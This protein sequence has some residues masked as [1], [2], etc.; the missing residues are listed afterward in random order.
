[1]T[2]IALSEDQAFQLGIEAYIYGYPLILMDITKA[3]STTVSAPQGFKAPINQ[4]AHL[5]AFPDASFTAVVSPNAD[6]LYSAAWLD[7]SSEPMVLSVPDTKGRYYLMPMLDAWTNVFASPGKRTT[8]TG[9]GDF[10]I[11]APDWTGKLPDGVQKIQSPTA[12]VW[13][14]GRTQ[15]NGKA[16]YEAV[17]AIQDQYQLTPLSQ[18]GK[19]YQP[20]TNVPIAE[21]IDPQ[22]APVE[23]VKN[24]DAATFFSRMS[25]L[26]KDNPPAPE[27]KEMVQK[28]AEI[29]I[30]QGEDFNFQS[31]DPAVVKGLERSVKAGQEKVVADGKSPKAEVKNHWLMTYDLGN[32]G[33]NY[34]HRAGVAWVGLG[35]N[36]PEDAIY[37]M[38]RVDEEGNLLT[39]E[40]RYVIHF[41][42][43][44]IPPV[45][46]FW[47]ITMY[48]N[49]QFFVDN[50]LNR[51]A[52]GDRDH[53]SF[54]DDGSLD[55]Y[56]QHES[57][58]KNQESNWLPSPSDSFNLIMRLYSPKTAVLDKK[59]CPP[60]VKQIS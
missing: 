57:P 13:L 49:Q 34:L 20:P 56:I 7:L 12:I 30:M 37:P 6:T 48:N 33:T 43:N 3:L 28:L 21:G 38:I 17:H 39:G 53:L 42:P 5:R 52:I 27:D 32:Y 8:G 4:F 31:L 35:A 23:Q 51:Y 47:S 25:T 59:W 2:T 58:D 16:D 50:P 41:E 14:I 29:G 22:T 40:H 60:P 55:I 1:M 10:A 11:V 24:L 54:N 18:W 45:N 15:T 46:A 36:L 19:T 9:K 44:E 26:M